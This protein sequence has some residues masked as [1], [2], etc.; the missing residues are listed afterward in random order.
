MNWQSYN[1][2]AG[3]TLTYRF[4]D[5]AGNL[6]AG[7]SFATLNRIWQGSPSEIAGRIQ[8]Q[9]GQN[10]QITLINQNGILFKDGAQISVGSLTASSLNITDALFLAGLQS[11]TDAGAVAAFLADGAG[12]GLVRVD[13][14][15]ELRTT[16]GGRVM[17]LGE[18]VENHGLIETP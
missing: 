17:L 8:V 9:P 13:S 7:A 4:Q 5:G 1:L 12:G 15:A 6:P 11:N 14:G 16:S 10:G 2:G 3:N 18:N